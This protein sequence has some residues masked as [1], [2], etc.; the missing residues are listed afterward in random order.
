MRMMLLMHTRGTA[1][2]RHVYRIQSTFETSRKQ[3]QDNQNCNRM[4]HLRNRPRCEPGM[5]VTESPWESLGE[6]ASVANPQGT[7]S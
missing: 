1:I 3:P 2:V 5:Q 6:D 4:F 7:L